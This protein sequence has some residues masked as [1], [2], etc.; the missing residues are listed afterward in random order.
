MLAVPLCG[1][2]GPPLLKLFLIK[3]VYALPK[4]QARKAVVSVV[5]SRVFQLREMRRGLTGVGRAV[6]NTP[7]LSASPRL[8]VHKLLFNLHKP[9]LGQTAQAAFKMLPSFTPL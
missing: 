1:I 5:L 6:S 7:Q 8:C 4:G 9:E 3:V 2:S